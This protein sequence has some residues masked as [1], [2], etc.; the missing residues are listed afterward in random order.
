MMEVVIPFVFIAWA[1]LMKLP[2]LR[3]SVLVILGK[4]THFLSGFVNL[5]L[6]VSQPKHF[7]LFFFVPAGGLFL[8][9]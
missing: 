8:N 9:P 3:P 5:L 4:M 2:V 1:F 7:L 6:K